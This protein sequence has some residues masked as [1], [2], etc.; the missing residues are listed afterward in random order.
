MNESTKELIKR[1]RK[2]N[3]TDTVSLLLMQKLIDMPSAESLIECNIQSLIDN[4]ISIGNEMQS[5]K[6]A[7]HKTSHI[8]D[9][10]RGAV[11]QI[12]IDGSYKSIDD[13]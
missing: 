2:P 7:T 3:Q 12:W 10:M 11:R 5:N 9:A 1:A 8:G 13:C 6:G 4:N